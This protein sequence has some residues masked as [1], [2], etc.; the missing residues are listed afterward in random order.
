[1]VHLRMPFLPGLDV[2]FDKKPGSVAVSRQFDV[3]G[4]RPEGFDEVALAGDNTA[5]LLV[6]L[7]GGDRDLC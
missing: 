6:M 1:M 2:S 5:I 7:D 4:D 3:E